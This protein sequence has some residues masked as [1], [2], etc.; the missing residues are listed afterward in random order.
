MDSLRI[1]EEDT[2]GRHRW[3][4]RRDESFGDELRNRAVNLACIRN[5]QSRKKTRDNKK[6]KKVSREREEPFQLRLARQS[7]SARLGACPILSS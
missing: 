3:R 4:S 5:N 7:V 6:Q 2:E 1:R